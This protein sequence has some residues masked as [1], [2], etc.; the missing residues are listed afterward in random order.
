MTRSDR[1]LEAVRGSRTGKRQQKVPTR[2]TTVEPD[3]FF[4]LLFHHVFHHGG[5][6]RIIGQRCMESQSTPHDRSRRPPTCRVH[7]RVHP[8]EPTYDNRSRGAAMQ[9]QPTRVD[10]PWAGCPATRA[11]TAD[12][13]GC[14]RVGSTNEGTSS[15]HSRRG[16]PAARHCSKQSGEWKTTPIDCTLVVTG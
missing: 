11:D 6:H 3:L 8:V 12:P 2:I 4:P 5:N 14:G 16:S 1:F 7:D 13:S 9:P 10:Y 15:E